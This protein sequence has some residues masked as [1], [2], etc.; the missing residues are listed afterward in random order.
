MGFVN[1]IEKSQIIL[2]VSCLWLEP[3]TSH[4][5]NKN[6]VVN[7]LQNRGVVEDYEY[8]LNVV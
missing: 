8:V 5:T 3:I 1:D 4:I 7:D 6:K 2:Q